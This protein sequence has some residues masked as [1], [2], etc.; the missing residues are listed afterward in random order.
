M[1]KLLLTTALCLLPASAFA[2]DTLTFR[3]VLHAT[4]AQSQDVGDAD[5]HA[6]IL[7]KFSG[8]V[9][10][11]DGTVGTSTLTA[12]ADYIKGNGTF[13]FYQRVETSDG[14][15]L[16]LKTTA[17]AAAVDGNITHLKGPITIIRGTGKFAG[18]KGDGIFQ[19]ARM[20]PDLAT[21]AET[22]TD[23][24]INLK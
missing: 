2:S 9:S 20:Q 19:G 13:A 3:A 18:A 17:G 7:V 4:A 16:V 22:Y 8:L 23:I 5:G 24:V 6:M 10:F 21:G 15:T 14:S 12:A 11:A 1:R